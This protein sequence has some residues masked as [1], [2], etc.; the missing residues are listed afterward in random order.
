MT[1][2]S[3]NFGHFCVH[4]TFAIQFHDSG[5]N[6]SRGEILLNIFS[7]LGENISEKSLLHSDNR[8]LF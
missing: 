3:F 7:Q 1:K 4:V 8:Q 6:N 5:Y 2:Y